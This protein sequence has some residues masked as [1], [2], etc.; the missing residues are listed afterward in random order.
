MIIEKERRSR[1]MLIWIVTAAAAF[2]AVADSA[3]IK[4][5]HCEITIIKMSLH[6]DSLTQPAWGKIV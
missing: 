4:A 6:V 5:E 1:T 3:S 2:A